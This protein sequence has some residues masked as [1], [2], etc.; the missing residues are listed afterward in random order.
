MKIPHFLVIGEV[1]AQKCKLYNLN[2][3]YNSL[4]STRLYS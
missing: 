4:I 1:V 3:K 2:Q